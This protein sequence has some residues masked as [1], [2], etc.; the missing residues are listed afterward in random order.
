LTLLSKLI[1]READQAIATPDLAVAA[2][3]GIDRQRQ[4]GDLARDLGLD[5]KIVALAGEGDHVPADLAV[6]LV[7]DLVDLL[8]GRVVAGLAGR[9][10]R[11]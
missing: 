4:H 9:A 11:G 3:E 8:P 1:R 5:Q 10:H 6:G 2:V 7:V